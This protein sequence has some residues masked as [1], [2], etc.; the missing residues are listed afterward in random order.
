MR[1][2]P[3]CSPCSQKPLD[4]HRLGPKRRAASFV[5]LSGIGAVRKRTGMLIAVFG[6]RLPKIPV[7]GLVVKLQGFCYVGGI[8]ERF[9]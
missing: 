5:T 3:L 4:C 9:C 7:A 6:A 1:L 2:R 8:R